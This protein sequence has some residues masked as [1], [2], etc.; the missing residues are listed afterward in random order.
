MEGT[1]TIL[2]LH[3]PIMELCYISFY[4]PEGEVRGFTY[5]GCVT[6][7]RTS[8]RFCNCYKVQERLEMREQPYENF[9]DIIFKQTTTK[10]IL[11]ELYRLTA[12]KEKL[13]SCLLRSHH[14]LGLNMGHQEEKK[15]AV[16]GVTKL[17]CD[18]SSFA[19]HRE[20]FLDSAKRDK[21]NSKKMRKYRRKESSEFRHWKGRNKV[22]EQHPSLLR[23][24]GMQM[25][26]EKMLPTR[27]STRSFPS[28]LSASSCVTAKAKDYLSPDVG[29]QPARGIKEGCFLES[30]KA[31]ELD[32]D[33]ACSVSKD[34]SDKIA[35]ELLD[36]AECI[37]EIINV[38]QSITLVKSSQ[39]NLSNNLEKLSKSAV[40]KILKDDKCTDQVCKEKPGFRIAAEVQD[41][42]SCDKAAKT[43]VESLSDFHKEMVSPILTAVHNEFIS[44]NNG[45]SADETAGYSRKS[46]LQEEEQDSSVLK[47]KAERV[48]ITDESCNLVGAVNKALLKVIQS[49]SLDEAAEWKRLKQITR[50]DRNLPGSIYE[51]K[52]T[53]S[54]GNN[55]HLFLNLP[56]NEDPDVSWTSNKLEEKKLHSPSLVAVSNVF[57]NSY[58]LSNT[59]KQMSPI[60]SP[61]SSRLPSPQ[62][63]HRI[64]PLPAQDSEDE[65]MFGDYCSGR[66]SAIN[67]S[68]NDLEPPFYLKFSEPGELGFT[69][70]QPCLHRNATAGH[71]EKR[72]LQER[73]TTQTQQNFCLP[74]SYQYLIVHKIEFLTICCES[75][76]EL[77]VFH[78]RGEHAVSTAQLEETIAHLKNE[79]DN[80]L[81]RRNE[82]ARDIGV[83]TEDDNPPKTYR[84][85]CIQTD[86]ETFIKPSEEENR[87]VKNNQ[88]VPKKLN[89]CSL[90]HSISTQGENKDSYD[91]PSSESLVPPPPPLPTGPTS[92]TPHFASGPP[93]PPQLSE[94]CRDFQAPS[95]PAPPPLPG[96]G[97][98]VPPPLPG[99][100][101]PPPPPPPGPGFFFN[102]TLSSSQGPRKPA[103]E[104]SRPMKPL[105]WTRIQLQGSRKTAIPTL[106]ESLEE[107][108]ILDTTEFEYLFS[109][110]TTQEKRKPLSETYEKKTKAK[111]VFNF[112]FMFSTILC[113]DDSVVDLETLEALYE[114]VSKL[115]LFLYELSQIPNFTERAQCIIFQSVFSEGITSVHRKV[116][117]ITRVSKDNRINLVD[118]VVI[119]YLR[120]C[121]KVEDSFAMK[122]F[123][124]L[125]STTNGS[126]LVFIASEKQMK[127]VC[128]ESSEEHLQPFK[129]KLEEF[130]QKGK[131]ISKIWCHL[132]I[133]T[134]QC[135]CMLLLLKTAVLLSPVFLQRCMYQHCSVSGAVQV[136]R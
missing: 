60:P 112:S 50:V 123:K 2:Q 96:L 74:P 33:L 98:P 52:T 43:H 104:P 56:V 113:V 28:S 110:D 51:K 79:F 119:Y 64:L 7:D 66:H 63:H 116:D 12:E 58:L 20:F 17:K 16:S 73:L 61:L 114:N 89:I 100:G 65:P 125:I 80:K 107:P 21:L 128:R 25:S 48:H 53:V 11:T 49:D 133:S 67:L 10:D 39:D 44:R 106:W 4:L 13:L 75:Q 122:A 78:I 81:N 14:I 26:N 82:E 22:H 87:A 38:H 101:L 111:K 72:T 24:R 35:V 105:Y 77:R 97:P 76:F 118:Y 83:S 29:I 31:M 94:G 55:K 103:I 136:N 5:R 57:S 127:L 117:I 95:P 15:Q 120:H 121:D 93:L 42:D 54:R 86:R 130:F 3:K 134:R 70:R 71:F 9:R 32:A 19:Y 99:S 41:S 135:K 46:V 102:S 90:T 62:L 69:I 126:Q 109:K 131:H 23:G 68:F 129:E 47:Y 40:A 34:N 124:V 85:V 30:N 45:Y 132:V 27:L 91:V 1:H 8:K 92:V 36:N 108:D 88:I 59:H 84:N 115:C 6:L 37:P 18:D